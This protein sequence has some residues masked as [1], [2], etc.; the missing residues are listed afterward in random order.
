VADSSLPIA[1]LDNSS[2]KTMLMRWNL[3]FSKNLSEALSSISEIS[4]AHDG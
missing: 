1:S 3:S 4:A 2:E